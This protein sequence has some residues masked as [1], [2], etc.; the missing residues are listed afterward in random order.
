NEIDPLVWWQEKQCEYPRLN[1]IAQ[2][3]LCVQAT[4]VAS[5][6]A[7]LIAGQMITPSRN[8]LGEK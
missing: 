6:Q 8:R 1:L 4:S 5:K 7:F 3:Y 2:D